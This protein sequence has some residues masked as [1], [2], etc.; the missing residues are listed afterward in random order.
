MQLERLVS[1][2]DDIKGNVKLLTCTK[3]ILE[4]DVIFSTL[5]PTIHGWLSNGERSAIVNDSM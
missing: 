5:T 3:I 1:N 2:C 4:I